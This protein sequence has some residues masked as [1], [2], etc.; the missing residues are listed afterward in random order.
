MADETEK[1]GS[2]LSISQLCLRDKAFTV[3]A[4]PREV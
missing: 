2:K 3:L 4:R 1:T